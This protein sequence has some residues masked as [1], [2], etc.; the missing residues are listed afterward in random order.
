LASGLQMLP[1]LWYEGFMSMFFR[2]LFH[3]LNVRVG[4]GRILNMARC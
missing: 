1:F 3:Q 2:W 4:C